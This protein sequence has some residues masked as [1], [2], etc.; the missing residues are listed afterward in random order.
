MSHLYVETNSIME[1]WEDK[2]LYFNKLWE[3]P[4][5]VKLNFPSR[6]N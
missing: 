4:M 1:I 6:G 5:A 3:D 2:T